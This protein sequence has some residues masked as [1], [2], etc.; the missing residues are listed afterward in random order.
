M[1]ACM[2]FVP[3]ATDVI[4]TLARPG[5]DDLVAQMPRPVTFEQ[6]RFARRMEAWAMRQIGKLANGYVVMGTDDKVNAALFEAVPLTVIIDRA[7]SPDR[8][9]QSIWGVN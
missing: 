6:Q 1:F 7:L 4:I 5:K 8:I 9:V 3:T 2:T